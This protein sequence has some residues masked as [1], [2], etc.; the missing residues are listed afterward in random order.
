MTFFTL[1][2]KNYLLYTLFYKNYVFFC[3]YLESGGDL[4]GADAAAGAWLLPD[5]ATRQP[6]PLLHQA[7]RQSR[8]L[9]HHQAGLGIRFLVFCKCRYSTLLSLK[10]SPLFTRRSSASL[11]CNEPVNVNIHLVQRLLEQSIRRMISCS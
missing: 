10:I 7:A 11:S 3:L 6:R 8:P 2:Y 9:L 4:C 5:E 1:Y